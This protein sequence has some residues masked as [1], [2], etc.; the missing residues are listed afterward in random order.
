MSAV[1]FL[2]GALHPSSSRETFQRGVVEAVVLLLLIAGVETL[3]WGSGY[4]DQLTLHPYW[5]VI[6]LA[7]MQNGIAV[8]LAASVVAT[9]LVGL[10]DRFVNEDAA[11]YAARAAVLPLQWFVVALIVGFYRQREIEETDGLRADVTRLEGA[12]ASLA[13][14]VERMDSLLADLESKAASQPVPAAVPAMEQLFQEA[15]PELA[16]LAGSSGSDLPR[17]F[18]DAADVLFTGPVALVIGAQGRG[19]FVIGTTPKNEADTL[20]LAKRVAQKLEGQGGASHTISLKDLGSSGE[21]VVRVVRQAARTDRDMATLLI[22][23]TLDHESAEA[24]A[25]SAEILSQLSRIA[26]DRLSRALDTEES[27]Q[28]DARGHE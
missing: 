19:E 15:L 18:E 1:Q 20:V 9:L 25:A 7:A 4:F 27:C 28:T 14:E 17:T 2:S 22:A 5:I 12:S 16:A 11:V 24:A 10:P 26:I 6:I 23:Y 13:D 21:G 3:F 8:G